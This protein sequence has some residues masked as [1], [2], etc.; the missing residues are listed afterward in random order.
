MSSSGGA[1]NLFASLAAPSEESDPSLFH[2]HRVHY[3]E[4][5]ERNTEH[6]KNRAARGLSQSQW[7]REQE[8]S[9]ESLDDRVYSEFDA[10]VHILKEGVSPAQRVGTLPLD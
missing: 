7:M 10:V 8:I 4:H 5:P 1:L 9:F 6:W 2:V 3:S